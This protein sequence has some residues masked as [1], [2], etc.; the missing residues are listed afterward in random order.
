[1]NNLSEKIL[2]DDWC[3]EDASLAMIDDLLL[4]FRLKIDK[5]DLDQPL[6]QS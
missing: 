5:D 6:K 4:T 3:H 1:M 2:F